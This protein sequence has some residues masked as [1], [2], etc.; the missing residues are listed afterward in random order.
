MVQ[1]VSRTV[2]SRF[3]RDQTFLII[4]CLFAL[5][6]GRYVTATTSS[7]LVLYSALTLTVFSV[8]VDNCL[9]NWRRPLGADAD[10]A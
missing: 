7:V 2:I 3:G 4:P 6:I 9:V 5:A 8:S 1:L 10:A